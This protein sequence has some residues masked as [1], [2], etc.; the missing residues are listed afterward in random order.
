VL[1]LQYPKRGQVVLDR[2]SVG[3]RGQRARRGVHVGRTADR[4]HFAVG[5]A[6]SPV[7]AAV[8]ELQP[9]QAVLSVDPMGA[10]PVAQRHHGR[11]LR[12]GRTGTANVLLG[13]HSVLGFPRD[14]D[15]VVRCRQLFREKPETVVRGDRDSDVIP[16]V[17]ESD[18]PAGGRM[19]SE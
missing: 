12:N 17:G 13:K 16:V 2:T 18:S 4:A 15:H 10:N 7:E 11:R 6:V 3:G 19:A 1:Q 14:N 5:R 8:F 9:R